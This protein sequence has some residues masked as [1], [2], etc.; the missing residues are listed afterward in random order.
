MVGNLVRNAV[1]YGAPGAA[2]TVRNVGSETTVTIH[3]HNHGKAIAG[4]VLPTLFEPFKR[5]ER[6]QDSERSVGLGLFIVREI[7]T[8][9]GGSVE[10][11]SDP[12][13]GTSF[14]VCRPQSPE[15]E[16]VDDVEV[17]EATGAIVRTVKAP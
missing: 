11:R 16:D 14:Q 13:D 10:V 6:R 12:D 3:V 1:S 4:D 17:V 7:V 5:G 9:H 15:V 2:I 8:A